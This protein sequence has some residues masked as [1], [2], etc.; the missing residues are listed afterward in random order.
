MLQVWKLRS[1]KT[2]EN[3]LLKILKNSP[4]KEALAQAFSCEFCEISKET[5]SYRTPPV[6]ASDAM[7]YLVYLHK[8]VAVDNLHALS[9]F[10]WPQV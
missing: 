1:R 2:L 6:A 3:V 9:H 7:Q 10:L 5:F 4:A 8:I